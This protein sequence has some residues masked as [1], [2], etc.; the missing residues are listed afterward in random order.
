MNYEF[1]ITSLRGGATKQSP[2]DIGAVDSSTLLNICC[3]YT[4][5]VRHKAKA[6]IL[7]GLFTSI[8]QTVAVSVCTL[9]AAATTSTESVAA[10]TS[11]VALTS[12]GMFGSSLFRVVTNRLNPTI[13]ML[14]V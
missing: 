7:T 3:G 2:E 4:L 12:L 13:S 14:T 1:E 9:V 8:R 5:Q 11:S 10:P 6:Q